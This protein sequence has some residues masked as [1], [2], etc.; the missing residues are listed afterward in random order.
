MAESKLFRN[1]KA[2]TLV[3]LL[4]VIA[5]IGILVALLLPAV[6]K[7]REAAQRLQCSNNLRQITFAT[8]NYE[9]NRKKLPAGGYFGNSERNDRGTIMIYLLPYIEEQAMYDAF[10]FNTVTDNQKLPNGA[11][12]KQQTI[13]PYLCPSSGDQQTYVHGHAKGLGLPSVPSNYGASSGPTKRGNNGAHSCQL[14][15]RWNNSFRVNGKDMSETG[16]GGSG[17]DKFAGVFHRRGKQVKLR[18]VKD[19]LSKTI[20]IGETLAQCSMHVRNGWAMTNNG[21][22]LFTTLI[23]LNWENCDDESKQGCYHPWNWNAEL[24]FKSKHAG[25][26]QFGYGDG[27]VHMLETGIDPYV[28]NLLGHKDDGVPITEQP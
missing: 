3:E 15:S 7:A 17:T 23:P 26:V 5:I 24:G 25:G 9:S 19:G 28:L 16:T 12:I 13:S 6:Q 4:V 8:L 22:G 10:D 11:L 20:F 27:S 1:R 18:E 2:F 14:F 21:Q